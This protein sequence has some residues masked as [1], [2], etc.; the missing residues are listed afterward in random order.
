MASSSDPAPRQH[1]VKG[2]YYGGEWL[3]LED[4]AGKFF[5]T[6]C[7]GCDFQGPCPRSRTR[8]RAYKKDVP[9]SSNANIRV[10]LYDICIIGAGC[11]GAAIARE[12]SKYKDLSILWLE[13]ADDVSQGATKGNSGIVH[14]GYDDKPGSV[15]A[16]HCW[17]GNQMFAE[18]DRQ[19]RFGYQ[20]NGSLVLALN[21]KEVQTLNELKKRGETNG[22]KRLRIVDRDEL[23]R[24]EP[25]VNPEAIAALY[26]PDAGNV[27]PYEFA[28]ALAENAVDNGVELRIRS[29]VAKITHDGSSFDVTVQRWE[30]KEYVDAVK[31]VNSLLQ[32]ACLMLAF[33]VAGHY[34][35]LR[36]SKV[37]PG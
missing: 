35:T 2:V 13:A 7:S 30:P 14:A 8:N 34:I 36:L 9:S 19:L 16:Q 15:R 25:H 22:V 3:D 20:K 4:C 1:G 37:N 6:K 27:I 5:P 18:L 23:H 11:I 10:P 33:M 26:S 32:F 12:L 17:K 24:M 31:G 28:I 29:M 21:E